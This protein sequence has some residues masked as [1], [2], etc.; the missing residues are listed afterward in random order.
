MGLLLKPRELQGNGWESGLRRYSHYCYNF[1]DLILRVVIPPIIRRNRFGSNGV[2]CFPLDD[3]MH[4]KITILARYTVLSRY[5]QFGVDF[6]R[7][8][9]DI[10]HDPIPIYSPAPY[11]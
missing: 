1:H 4:H 6:C 10:A 2:Y 7:P 11:L 8:C 3:I 9:T 5:S